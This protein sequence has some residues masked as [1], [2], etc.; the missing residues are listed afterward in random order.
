MASHRFSTR[1]S[2]LEPSVLRGRPIA[3]PLRYKHSETCLLSQPTT[4][5]KDAG[6][7]RREQPGS[8]ATLFVVRNFF[9]AE[10]RWRERKSRHARRHR[11]CFAST[12]GSR[13]CQIRVPRSRPYLCAL[14]CN[15]HAYDY[16]RILNQRPF[17]CVKAT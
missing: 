2:R 7:G 15:D 4:M 1:G 6:Y 16:E 12:H 13:A 14:F 8:L 3:R 5:A 11:F 17:V 10:K 9:P